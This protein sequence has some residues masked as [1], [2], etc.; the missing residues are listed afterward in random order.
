MNQYYKLNVP[1]YLHLKILLHKLLF[2][3]DENDIDTTTWNETV[4]VINKNKYLLLILLLD[5]TKKINKNYY[6]LLDSN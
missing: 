2:D 6:N 1:N 4:D 3:G 5:M